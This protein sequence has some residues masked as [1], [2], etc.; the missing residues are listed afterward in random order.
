MVRPLP[1]VKMGLAEIEKCK[2]FFNLSARQLH[3]RNCRCRG[4]ANTMHDTRKILTQIRDPMAQ[5]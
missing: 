3:L 2:Q 5:W 1:V 4:M